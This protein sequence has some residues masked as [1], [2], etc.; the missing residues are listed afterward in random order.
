[1]KYKFT[2]TQII[3]VDNMEEAKDKLADRSWQFAANADLR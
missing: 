2:S 1:M 3:E